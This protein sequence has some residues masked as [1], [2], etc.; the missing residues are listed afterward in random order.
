MLKSSDIYVCQLATS[1]SVWPP[2]PSSLHL[3]IVVPIPV[4]V[5]LL[6]PENTINTVHFYDSLSICLS[7]CLS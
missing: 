6:I 5:S 3:S 1:S 7:A 2:W 4:V